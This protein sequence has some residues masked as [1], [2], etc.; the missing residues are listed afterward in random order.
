MAV[1]GMR[2]HIG[3]LI[4]HGNVLVFIDDKKGKIRRDETFLRLPVLYGK[5]EKLSLAERVSD[6]YVFAVYLDPTLGKFQMAQ[7][8]S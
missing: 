1:R 6:G 8:R 2:R 4:G 7:K 3:R 5:R